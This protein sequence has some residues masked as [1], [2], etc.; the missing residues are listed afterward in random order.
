MSG[1][2]SSFSAGL[3]VQQWTPESL[4]RADRARGCHYSVVADPDLTD[5]V[6]RARS[7]DQS[8]WAAL[9]RRFQPLVWASVRR[10]RMPVEDA[11][12]A[13]QLTWLLLASNLHKLRDPEAIAGWLATTARREALRLANRRVEPPL[14]EEALQRPGADPA[15]DAALLREELRA[16]VRQAW[17]TLDR[18]CQQLLAML[19]ADPPATY[20]AIGRALDLPL[21]S[22]GPTRTRCLDRLRKA[23]GL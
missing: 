14:S 23:S 13:S 20:G 16:Q 12:D 7:G 6:E 8:A 11:E 4:D 19:A 21:G 17:Q 22:V 15:V 18:R 10:I 5:L 3:N 9:V 1:S 2:G